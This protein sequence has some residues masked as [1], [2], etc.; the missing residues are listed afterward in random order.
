MFRFVSV[1]FIDCCSYLMH[2]VVVGV[3][4]VKLLFSSVLADDILCRCGLLQVQHVLTLVV[5]F[6]KHSCCW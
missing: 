5:Q 2:V 6:V 1:Q 3:Y 4:E